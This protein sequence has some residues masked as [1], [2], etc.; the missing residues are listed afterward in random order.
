MRIVTP[1]GVF[2][3]RSDTWMLAEIVQERVLPGTS[4]LDLCTGSGALA[5]AAALGGARDVT[6]VDISRR[7]ALAVRMNAALNRVRVRALRGDLFAPVAGRR[8]DRIVTNPPY[9]PSPETAGDALPDRGPSRAWE[10]GAGGRA[11]IDRIVEAAPRH[12]RPGGELLMVHSSVCGTEDTISALARAGLEPE[13][14][15]CRAGPPGPLLAARAPELTDEELVAI[16][17]ARMLKPVL[18]GSS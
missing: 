15:E 17:G 10:G 4:V 11:F 16:R 9:L 7:S 2:R 5:V 18:S 6:A 14:V 13:V 12:L 3:P 8:F 1:P